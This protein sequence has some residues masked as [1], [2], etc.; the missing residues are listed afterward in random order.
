MTLLLISRHTDKNKLTKLTIILIILLIYNNVPCIPT[1]Y[2]LAWSADHIQWHFHLP[3]KATITTYRHIPPPRPS[4]Y[5][6]NQPQQEPKTHDSHD[7]EDNTK[8]GGDNP[9]ASRGLPALWRRGK[10]HGAKVGA[11]RHWILLWWNVRKKR[12]K[13]KWRSKFITMLSSGDV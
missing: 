11:E 12:K 1:Q 6:T 10:G 13:K 5:H 3:N 7:L 2:T 9:F 4:T 8:K